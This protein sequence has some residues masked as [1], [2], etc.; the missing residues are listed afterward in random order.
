MLRVFVGFF[1][2]KKLQEWVEKLQ[3][4]SNGFIKGK[5]VE[6]QN[7]HITFHFIGEVQQER[8]VDILKSLQETSQKLKPVRVRYRGLG[9]FP[10]LDK[11]RVLWIGVAGGHHQLVDIA[12]SIV[13]AN[14]RVGIKEEGKPF[15]P[16][17]TVC[18]IK[19]FEIKP[20]KDLLRLYENTSFGEDV[21]DRVALVKSSLTAVGPIYTVIEE[22]YFRG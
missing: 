11:A 5:W 2:T 9:V 18:R 21:V 13:K 3:S 1:V 10:S 12:K 8:L 14:R 19:E 4:Q 7:F 15:H 17:V 22:F 20:M 16:H 6:P